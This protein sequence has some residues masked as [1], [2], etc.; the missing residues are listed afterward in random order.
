MLDNV[1]ELLVRR[2]RDVRHAVT[3]LIPPAWQHDDEL[4]ADVRAFHGYHAGLVEAGT[5]QPESSSPTAGWLARRSTGTAAA[6]C[7]AR[8]RRRRARGVLV[9]A[10]AVPLSETTR[11][12]RGRLGPGE[13]LAVDPAGAGLEE[14][15]AVKRRLAER[16]PYLRWLATGRR[17]R[18]RGVPVLPPREART[19][20]VL[21]G[22]TR[23][24]ISLVCGRWLR[25]AT[26]RF[27]RWA[28]TRRCRRSP[29]I[30][31]LFGF[32]RQRFAQVTNPA[33]DHV[34]ERRVMS[35]RT[36]LEARGP[37]PRRSPPRRGSSSWTRSC[38]I[39][40]RCRRSTRARSTRRCAGAKASS[41]RVHASSPRRCRA[42][43]PDVRFC[44]SATARPRGRAPIPSLLALAALHDGLVA[45]G[46]RTNASIVVQSD[47]PRET[48]HFACLLGFGADAI[49]PRLALETVAELAA[50]DKLGGD[51]PSPAGH[52]S[53]TARR[54]RT[55]C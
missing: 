7:G 25:R 21:F 50:A 5:A 16:R 49:C 4:D 13:M 27:R 19:R 10:G 43:A 53:A 36:L 47:E 3:M 46:L 15:A 48:H 34:R 42:S 29:G 11:V 9:E 55:E 35:L 24:E 33:I 30:R 26:R 52:R 39:P 1:L 54:S 41:T 20:H 2:G 45:A 32:F 18:N 38:S 14:D 8:R 31:P 37:R 23:E 28:T 6:A 44:C 40:R 17:P 22:Y 12:R 51:H